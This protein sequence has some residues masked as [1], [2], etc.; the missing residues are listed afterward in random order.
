MK[1]RVKRF[2]SLLHVQPDLDLFVKLTGPLGVCI[3]KAPSSHYAT[4]D[5]GFH[6]NPV[7]FSNILN[8]GLCIDTSITDDFQVCLV[9]NQTLGESIHVFLGV[10]REKTKSAI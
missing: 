4:M 7:S 9:V 2:K 6:T 10:L 8:G 3:R 5:W 1:L